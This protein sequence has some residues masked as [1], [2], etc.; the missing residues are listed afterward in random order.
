[1][2]HITI[3]L[4]TIPTLGKQLDIKL[5][6]FILSYK[7]K[8]FIVSLHHNIP[9]NNI[10][11]EEGNILDIHINSL[12][13]EILI[14]KSDTI[15][16]TDY[17]VFN[18]IQNKLPKNGDIMTVLADTRYN[19]VTKN[20]TMI[21]FDNLSSNF[22]LPYI[23]AEF[24]ESVAQIAGL[25]GS[26]VIINNKVVGIFSKYNIVTKTVY[27]VPIYIVIKNLDKTNNNSIFYCNTLNVKKINT[28]NVKNQEIYHPTFK[29][30][31]NVN[32][33]FLIEGDDN[34]Y[35]NIT[36]TTNDEIKQQIL[37]YQDLIADNNNEIIKDSNSYKITSRFLTLINRFNID[38]AIIKLI[39]T[40]LNKK[41]QRS[42]LWFNLNDGQLTI[43]SK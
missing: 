27:I 25:S 6:S 12:W 2:N 42:Q 40:K 11:D 39:F 32:S 4:S 31:I 16:C 36:D 24:T 29:I 21:P 3:N 43:D 35:V 41:E 34:L 18:E 14:L 26:P 20:I 38:K 8:K 23:T 28:F 5:N 10:T 19:M 7:S 17:K 9:I 22:S 33:Y 37:P 13:S 30:N 1:M 15:N